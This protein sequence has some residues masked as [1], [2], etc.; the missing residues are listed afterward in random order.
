ML[1]IE[2]SLASNV[3]RCT[4]YRPILEAFKRF[5]KDSPNPIQDIEDLTICHKTGEVC[6]K[7]SC[8]EEDWCL[9]S[10]EEFPS[11][12]IY[13]K[14]HDNKNWFRPG[15]LDNVIDILLTNGTSS[16]MLVAGNT[17]K[18]KSVNYLHNKI[19]FSVG[20]NK[21]NVNSQLTLLAMFKPCVT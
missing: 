12:I 8:E 5:A 3:C 2:K 18:G 11:S 19:V 17:G 20:T 15:T 7:N 10:K 16:Y 1:E 13:V 21:F 14:L 4:G 9:V 6:D